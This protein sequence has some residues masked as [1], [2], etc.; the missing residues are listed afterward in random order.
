MAHKSQN[1]GGLR[2]V[3]TSDLKIRREPRGRGF[4]YLAPQGGII[5]DPRLLVRLKRLAVPPAYENVRYAEDPR[6]HIQAVGRDVAGRRQYR[7]HPQWDEVRERRKARHLAELAPLL[8]KL[9]VAI[10]R[11]LKVKEPS[12]EFALAAVIDLI[13][14]TAIRGGSEAYAREHG[15]RGA[16]TLLKSNASITGDRIALHFR[17]KGGKPVAKELR[18][19]K[20]ARALRRLKQL[21]GSRLFQ[22]RAADGRIA[23]VHRRDVNAFLKS[24]TSDKINLKDLRTLIA[25]GYALEEFSALDPK[26]SERGRRKQIL[27]TL[28]MVAD[29]LANTPAVCRK[30]YVHTAIV[31]AFEA[32][33]LARMTRQQP[34]RSTAARE[35]LLGQML[36]RIAGH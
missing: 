33:D 7:Y 27:G 24:I 32:G 9:R 28:R 25:C 29:E 14:A 20:L 18:S 35:R 19:A 30:S 34:I 8:P 31:E 11:Y 21:P 1:L 10:S 36:S 15:T 23:R 6:A 12:R 22:Y 3:E 17:G 26:A 13:A 16:A 4:I 5:R 2:H